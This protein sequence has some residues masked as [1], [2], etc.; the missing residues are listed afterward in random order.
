MTQAPFAPRI[1]RPQAE[2]ALVAG[3]SYVGA[4]AAA[5]VT[6]ASASTL[7]HEAFI[8]AATGS[9]GGVVGLLGAL[10]IRQI[11]GTTAGS[12]VLVRHARG[13]VTRRSGGKSKAALRY[14]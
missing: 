2:A 4:A 9:I 5:A 10:L 6:A 8:A 13:G 14:Q 12:S 1:N 11:C 3:L 7:V